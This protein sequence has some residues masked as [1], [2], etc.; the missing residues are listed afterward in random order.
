MSTQQYRVL[1]ALHDQASAR[2]FRSVDLLDLSIVIAQRGSVPPVSKIGPLTTKFRGAN[3][4]TVADVHAFATAAFGDAQARDVAIRRASG[5]TH[6]PISN[7]DLLAIRV[8]IT[9]SAALDRLSPAAVIRYLQAHGWHKDGDIASRSTGRT[10][11]LGSDWSNGSQTIIVPAADVADRV[12]RIAEV[13]TAIAV[14]ERR[15]QMLVYRD[16]LAA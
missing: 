7:E 11:P 6:H 1:T 12:L 5:R 4:L 10:K 13:V 14:T 3:G 16:L 8:T 15:S 2:G 9:D